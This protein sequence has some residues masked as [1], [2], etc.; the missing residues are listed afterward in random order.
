MSDPFVVIRKQVAERELSNALAA[1]RE[2]SIIIG[3]YMPSRHESP[4]ELCLSPRHFWQ[5]QLKKL[6]M[7]T[8]ILSNVRDAVEGGHPAT[9][10]PP[11]PTKRQNR[12]SRA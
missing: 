11:L 3:Q 4:H 5:H 1:V 10:V 7:A 9:E 2:A 8:G 6:K 12:G